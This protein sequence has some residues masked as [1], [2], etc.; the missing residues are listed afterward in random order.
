VTVRLLWVGKTKEPALAQAI[1]LYVKKLRPFARIEIVEIKEEKGKPRDVALEGE[2]ERILKQAGDAFILL[3]ERGE[4]MDSTGLARMLRDRSSAEFVL[5][6]PY[7]V[8]EGLRKEAGRH[9]L[10]LSRMTLTHEMAR[11]VLLEQVYRAMMI[12]SGRDYHH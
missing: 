7:G 3:D 8:S 4:Q 2:A 1:E 10:A 5:G 12:N 6:G 11:L 9:T